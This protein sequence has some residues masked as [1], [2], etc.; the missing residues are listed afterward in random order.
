MTT[1][2]T[3]T[4]ARLL[5]PGLLLG[6]GFGGFF[7]GIVLH[8]VLQWHHMLSAQDAAVPTFPVDTVAGLETNTLW[9]GLFHVT[10]LLFFLGGTAWL[11]SRLGDVRPL[12]LRALAGLLA[13]GWGLFNLVEGIVDHHLLQ[14]HHVR[15]DVADPLPWD[16]GF[17]ALGAV[18]LVG[19]LT[20]YR[21]SVRDRGA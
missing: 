20:L 1:S 16:L 15:D 6:V 5:G 4:R 9:D 8:Q 18:L 7:D 17:L 21:S 13:A 14:V 3:P 10:A 2:Q 19:G 11:W 12:P